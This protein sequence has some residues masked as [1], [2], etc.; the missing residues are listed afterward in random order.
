[1]SAPSQR[2]LWRPCP[3]WLAQWL[4]P[5]S[6]L[7]H[8]PPCCERCVPYEPGT[9]LQTT[10]SCSIAHPANHAAFEAG[11]GRPW[12]TAL[13]CAVSRCPRV[14]APQFSTNGVNN[15]AAWVPAMQLAPWCAE[16][17]ARRGSSS[18]ALIDGRSARQNDVSQAGIPN[19]SMQVAWHR[20]RLQRCAAGW[21]SGSVTAQ[22]EVAQT[23]RA[24]IL[25]AFM[26]S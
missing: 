26:V 11:Y 3:E 20:R 23:C 6:P 2:S 24:V 8:H 7:P 1:M 12:R 21:R 4:A 9:A 5:G 17:A 16:Q 22:I 13:T 15:S 25:G 10:F 19:P 18:N 14:N